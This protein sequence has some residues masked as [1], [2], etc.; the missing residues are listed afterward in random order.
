MSLVIRNNVARALVPCL[1]VAGLSALRLDAASRNGSVPR[2]QT[3]KSAK[4]GKAAAAR[5][6]G[7]DVQAQL[8]AARAAVTQGSALVGAFL[9][10]QGG[11]DQAGGDQEPPR[12]HGGTAQGG[13][14]PGPSDAAHLARQPVPGRR[15]ARGECAESRRLRWWLTSENEGAVLGDT[16]GFRLVVFDRV[17]I[18]TGQCSI[19]Q[20]PKARLRCVL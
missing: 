10:G 16:V 17:G 13:P 5:E 9:R 1:G 3:Q 8:A 15:R 6:L 12:P 4:A 18:S 19:L 2:R 20:Q 14:E 11:L 7:Q